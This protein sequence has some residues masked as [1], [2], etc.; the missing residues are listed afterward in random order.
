MATRI[1]IKRSSANPTATPS[2]VL[3]QGELAYAEGT[4]TYTDAQSA[5]VTSYGK[6]FVGKG[7]ETG[8]VAAG[9]DI[10]GGKYFTDLLDHGH[11]TLTANSAIIVDSAQKISR[12]NVDHVRVDGD[13][14]STETANQSLNFDTNGTGDYV[15]KGA[16]TV[17][18]NEFKISD[19]STDR[20]VVDSF[21]GAV[22]ITTPALSAADT[23]LN[24][25]STWNNGS[26]KFDAIKVNVTNT[27]SANTSL[28]MD[29]QVGG[30]SKFK[31]G[32]DGTVT[33][34]GD[35][36]FDGDVTIGGDLAVNGGDI[37]STSAT[38]NLLNTAGC[39]TVNAFT[40]A[41]TL[42]IGK[43][44]G[45]ATINNPT[46]VGT[47][48]TQNLWNTTATTVNFAGAANT[49]NM[50]TNV[51]TLDLGY[52]RI[53]GNTI[54]TDSNSATELIIDPFPD[55]GDAGGDV[56]IRG[57]L[58]VAGT[59]TTV[60]STEM[61]VNDP[62]FTV[63]DSV[64]SKTVQSA[65]SSGQN[66]LVVDNP[67]SIVEGA[68]ITAGSGLA[69]GTTISNVRIEWNVGSNPLTTNPSAGDNI[70]FFDGTSF[71]L[72]GTYVSKTASTVTIDL[73]ANISTSS[74]DFYNGN[75]LTTQSSGTPTTAQKAAIQKVDTK[76][77]KT[78]TL[79][80]S[81]NTNGSLAV[82][83]KVTIAQATDDNLD[84]GIVYKT[85]IGNAAK[86]G[87]FGYDDSTTYFTFIADATNNAGVIGG[88]AGKAQFNTVKVDTG[89]NKGVAY[90]NAALELTR[91]VA[92]GTSD[93]TTSHKILTSN[94]AS[95]EPIWTTTVDGGTY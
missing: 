32:L 37:T 40:N 69:G 42:N 49:I 33:L 80:L 77:F 59:T 85:L 76:V 46:V 20:F 94:G 5:T 54:S 1:K 27:A 64:S 3:G 43:T 63:G 2:S 79:T 48:T 66:T 30:A 4:S 78:T 23:V 17:G 50:G 71:S 93:I 53:K 16:A 91:T 22:D 10:I 87:F 90:Y 81:A 28:L 51:T 45:T 61:S 36:N 72:L 38:F 7:S 24:I 92:A 75:S 41:G 35:G 60:N 65:A 12:L 67:S 8:G 18:T 62:L 25:T 74:D 11:G 88:S 29:L 14:I 6:L 83:D 82:G 89:V 56:I 15:F 57:N 73:A 68:T 39:T 34:P 95:G 86:T 9:L 84:R 70:Y 13:T 26:N 55:S 47:Q 58:Q 31:V 21:S 19:G 44:S 52:I